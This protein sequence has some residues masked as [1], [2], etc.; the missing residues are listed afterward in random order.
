MLHKLQVGRLWQH[1][2]PNMAS[3][4][5]SECLI[6]K[7]CPGGACL[8]TPLPYSHLSA[9]NGR[10]SLK[11]LAPALPDTCRTCG[12]DHKEGGNLLQEATNSF[13]LLLSKLSPRTTYLGA[14]YFVTGTHCY[15]ANL[16]QDSGRTR[17]MCDVN[18][19]SIWCFFHCMNCTTKMPSFCK[20]L[21]S[22]FDLGRVRKT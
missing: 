18:L 10:T 20:Y 1:F 14:I 12:I 16:S 4:V 21:I 19:N 17:N 13:H 3:E 15:I 5:I 11:Q 8:Q 2:G 9:R 7:I 22:N 6:F